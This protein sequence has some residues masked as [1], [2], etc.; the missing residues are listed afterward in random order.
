M[1]VGEWLCVQVTF[2]MNKTFLLNV[3]ISRLHGLTNMLM[4]RVRLVFE[5]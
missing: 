1:L 5:N 2:H 3:V 4:V